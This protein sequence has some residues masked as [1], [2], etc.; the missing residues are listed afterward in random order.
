MKYDDKCGEIHRQQYGRSDKANAC[1]NQNADFQE[2]YAWGI[3]TF[4]YNSDKVLK[5]EIDFRGEFHLTASGFAEW[6]RG[7]WSAR[8]QM[9]HAG[10]KKLRIWMD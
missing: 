3:E 1:D 4:A 2:G 5:A 7:F 6:K 8:N 9:T 10:I